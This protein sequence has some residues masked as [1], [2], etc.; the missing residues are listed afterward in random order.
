MES[1]GWTSG[2]FFSDLI[3]LSSWG[4][5]ALPVVGITPGIRC[6]KRAKVLGLE[7]ALYAPGTPGVQ[8]Q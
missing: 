8:G 2:D 7:C 3:S 1:R 4:L 5:G 6:L